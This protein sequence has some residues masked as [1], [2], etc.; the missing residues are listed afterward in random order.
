MHL[1]HD[2]DSVWVA[3]H[4]RSEKIHVPMASKIFFS[5]QV[6]TP[7]SV[8][9]N[10]IRSV[11]DKA[12]ERITADASVEEAARGIEVDSDTQG[13]AGQPP[14]V[15]TIFKKIDGAQVFIA[16]MTFVG[17]R[18][19]GRPTPNP[20]VLI[21]YGWALKGGSYERIICIANTVYG[22]ISGETLPFNMRHVKWPI[23]YN[24][25]ESAT[26]TEKKAETERLVKILEGAIRASLGSIPNVSNETVSFPR[27]GAKDGPARFRKRGESLGF[28]DGFAFQPSREV[29][30]KEGPAMWL[31]VMPIENPGKL[32]PIHEIKE[33]ALKQ[34]SN[35]L[36]LV[37]GGSGYNFLKAEDGIGMYRPEGD[38]SKK[39]ETDNLFTN[40]V[41][42]AFE[43]GEIWSVDTSLLSYAPTRLYQG[44]IENSFSSS[45]K[46]Y[47]DFL[48][49][50]GL[51]APFTWVAGMSGLRARELGYA[52]PPGHSFLSNRGPKCLTDIIEVEGLYDGTS[53][54]T[55]A[56]MPFFE[57]I[58][59]KC[60]LK[61]PAHLLQQ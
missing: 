5:W 11:L 51:E 15:D 34:T 47:V 53:T 61:R 43:T 40:G 20:N 6:D 24:L 57:R 49:Y 1:S 35:I 58:F 39:A 41:A 32:W 59:E 10:F 42:F 8:G 30:L 56:L 33:L 4:D 17:T 9:R 52:A 50:L 3:L 26:P 28:E 22:E 48:G 19:D 38:E 14:I 25:A 55:A 37:H 54:P 7:P 21:E 60:G 12:C 2:E 13:I 46:N 16:D 18:L 36:P 44:D 27:M 45:L 23:T 29:F 31:R